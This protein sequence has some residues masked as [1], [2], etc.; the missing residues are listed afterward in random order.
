MSQLNQAILQTLAYADI[1]DYPLTSGEFYKFLICHPEAKPKDLNGI[2]RNA[3]NDN[4]IET[5]GKYYFLKGRQKIVELRKKRERW[6]REKLKISQRVGKW[7][8][9]IPWIKMVGITGN[10]AMNNADKDDDIDILIVSQKGRVWLTRLVV[11]ILVEFM[12]IRRKPSK[13]AK[14]S[15]CKNDEIAAAT[16]WPRNDENYRNKICLNMFLDEDHLAVLPKERDLYTAHEV[17]QMKLLWDR[18]ECYRHFLIDNLWIKDYLTNGID[19]KIL[20]YYDTKR[21]ENNKSFLSILV[22]QYLN[23]MENL[24]KKLQLWYMRQR[25]TTEM[26]SDGVIRFHPQDARKWILKEYNSR[27]LTLDKNQIS[28][29]E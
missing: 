17:A 22:S 19:T 28:V 8:K 29:V 24:V 18:G 14:Q 6:S 12:G 10:L 5:D 3:Q 7:L 25:R 11:T 1:F 4:Y 16:S 20:R 26:I 15:P 27:L 13:R 9:I 23:I 21:R 2:L